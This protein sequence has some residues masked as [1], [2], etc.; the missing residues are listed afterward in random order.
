MRLF[1]NVSLKSKVESRG[2]VKH[3]RVTGV[4]RSSVS[5]GELRERISR[6]LEKSGAQSACDVGICR[7]GDQLRGLGVGRIVEC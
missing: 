5:P 7:S 6:K 1:S 3:I 4:A 2:G